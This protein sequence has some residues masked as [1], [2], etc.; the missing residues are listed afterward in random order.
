ME[1]ENIINVAEEGEIKG[2]TRECRNDGAR[3]YERI[4]TRE[5][6][7]SVGKYSEKVATKIS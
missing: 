4:I 6:N 1:S 5:D 7:M 2:A 3:W